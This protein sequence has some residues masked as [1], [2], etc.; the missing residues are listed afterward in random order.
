MVAPTPPVQTDSE[1]DEAPATPAKPDTGE[2]G[3]G[4]GQGQGN[5]NANGNGKGPAA[6][7]D[8]H[9][10][11]EDSEDDDDTPPPTGVDP[12][13]GSAGE[14]QAPAEAPKVEQPQ[15]TPSVPAAVP[16]VPPLTE[17]PAAPRRPTADTRTT[18]TRDGS[19]RSG[20][21]SPS[22]QPGSGGVADR[23]A[24]GQL[25]AAAPLSAVPTGGAADDAGSGQAEP[26]KSPRSAKKAA[27]EKESPVTRTV[28]D[29]VE[30]VPDSLKVALAALAALAV[31]L[32]GGYLFMALRARSLNH[33]RG[34]LL[35]EVGLLQGALLPAVPETLGA[36]RT[37]VAYRP[38]D[39]PGA[40]GD[41]YDVIPLAGE[42][43]GFILGDVSGHGRGALART[44]F[45]R[46]TL[47]A[48]LEAGLE[49][50]VALQVAGRVIDD[51]LGGDFATVLL[52]VHDPS[53]GSLT[54]A[55]AG[56][57]PPIVVGPGQQAPVTASSSPPIG[58]GLRTGLRQTTVPL[59]PGSVACLYTDGLSEARTET[60]ILGR[61]R[62][63]DIVSEM[64]RDAK[65][66]DL[67]ER[68]AAE[69]RIVS[70]DMA[71]CLIAPN[72]GVTA[73]G[74]RTE[75]LEVAASELDGPLARRFLEACGVDTPEAELAEVEARGMAD[76]FGGAILH[77]VL[78]N[79]RTVEVLPRNVESIETASRRVAAL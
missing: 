67:L 68:I 10:E 72:T 63:S 79:R 3:Q 65:A 78:G 2:T 20:A 18:D 47:R 1:D 15:A 29:I 58:I 71:T 42:R 66:E 12:A 21:G 26:R 11:N 49:P 32:S 50:R 19:R 61:G 44:A 27:V 41:F 30:V 55:S 40:G 24:S 34:E 25:A 76:R 23:S 77:V 69:A 9:E 36:V 62:L 70:D 35:Q 8:D 37:S 45:M 22:A 14:Q 38:A 31:V 57:P 53:T 46:Y 56:H 6:P 64:G 39:G 60:G 75:Q 51:N 59:A 4:N 73:G 5:G 43:V 48:Y 16:A 52:A 28:R 74:F 54:Y 17:V 7:T 33:Q 13:Q